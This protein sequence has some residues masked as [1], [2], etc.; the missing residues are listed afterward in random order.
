MK[1]KII[2][3]ASLLFGLSLFGCQPS[4][5]TAFFQSPI[6]HNSISGENADSIYYFRDLTPNGLDIKRSLKII[7]RPE[8]TSTGMKELL[9]AELITT[10][11]YTP[12]SNFIFLFDTEANSN[13]FFQQQKPSAEAENYDI[14]QDK[15]IIQAYSKTNQQNWKG[16]LRNNPLWD[17]LENNE[18]LIFYGSNNGKINY[19]DF[20][21]EFLDPVTESI[22]AHH[23]EK[24]DL[25]DTFHKS[26]DPEKIGK[27]SQSLQIDRVGNVY[28][29]HLKM[30]LNS[31]PPT[32]QALQEAKNIL[33]TLEKQNIITN[34]KI[35]IHPLKLDAEYQIDQ[36]ELLTIT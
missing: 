11:T 20:L 29:L 26:Y 9:L 33:S 5:Q 16:D 22:V 31:T 4:S 17:D 23:P 10:S 18:N 36:S 12:E 30:V 27:V 8:T 6:F 25:L 21:L 19:E 32:S 13:A 15:T 24:N 28:K 34:L 3:L 35:S 14:Q 2:V 1:Q 7:N